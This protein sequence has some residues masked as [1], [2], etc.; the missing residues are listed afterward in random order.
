MSK[1]LVETGPRVLARR[2]FLATAVTLSG[3]AVAL[4]AGRPGLVRAAEAGSADAAILKTALGAEY[5]A[6][7]AY[8]VGI[9]SGLLGAGAKKLAAT[10]RDHH[11]AH[12]DALAGA[13]RALKLEPIQPL[14]KYEFPVEQLKQE[15]DVLAF[16]AGL[17]RGAM[18]AYVGAIPLF[19]DRELARAAASILADEA[20]HWAVLRN[21]LGQEPVPEAFF[22]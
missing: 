10:F 12:A 11:R 20:M 9:D 2:G 3:A 8:G 17:E 15:A 6:I 5:N 13:M 16:A 18:S 4:L 22:T 19:G 1:T 21:A 7:A 14:A